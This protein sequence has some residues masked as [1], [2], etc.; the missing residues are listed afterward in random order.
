MKEEYDLRWLDANIDA[1]YVAENP[2]TATDLI[3]GLI[4]EY[5]RMKEVLELQRENVLLLTAMLSKE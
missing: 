4:T 1:E 2:E 5:Y 3:H